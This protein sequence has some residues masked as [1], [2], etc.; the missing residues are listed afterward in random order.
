MQQTAPVAAPTRRG[1]DVHT[2]KSIEGLNQEISSVLEGVHII[3]PVRGVGSCC[4]SCVSEVV[5][6]VAVSALLTVP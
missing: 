3:S 5:T 6:V 4:V 1:D 2:R